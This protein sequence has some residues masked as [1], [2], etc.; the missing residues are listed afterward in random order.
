MTCTANIHMSLSSYSA[1]PNVEVSLRKN[2]GLWYVRF[3]Y[4]LQEGNL[5]LVAG[6]GVHAVGV[7]GAAGV[8]GAGTLCLR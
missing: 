6:T 4:C 3:T 1:T 5:A 7:G 2:G 8:A